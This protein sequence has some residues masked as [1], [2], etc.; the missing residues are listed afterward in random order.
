MSTLPAMLDLLGGFLV[1]AGTAF[2]VV[3]TLGLLR[4]PDP[5]S[6]LHALTKADGA[7]L[8][9]CVVGLGLIALDMSA[10]ALMLVI[11]FGVM[12][13]GATIA[14]LVARR[15]LERQGNADGA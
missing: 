2:S 14:H 12:F 3:G 9:L 8:G 7:G 15:V 11:W 1:L 4:F 5:M 6:R 13:S 10:A